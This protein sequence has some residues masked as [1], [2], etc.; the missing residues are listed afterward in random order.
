MLNP[1]KIATVYCFQ[2]FCQNLKRVV[3][4]KNQ[5]SYWL[6]QF[7]VLKSV[8]YKEVFTKGFKL[9]TLSCGCLLSVI[10]LQPFALKLT[11]AVDHHVIPIFSFNLNSGWV[12][13]NYG[14]GLSAECQ[15]A[16]GDEV[17]N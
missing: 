11:F 17:E 13:E 5:P 14:L 12:H 16:R 3:N 9:Q 4:S 8:A 6:D 15:K 2:G 7:E 10:L 1:S